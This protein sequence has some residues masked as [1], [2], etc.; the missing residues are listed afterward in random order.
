ME[1]DL[2]SQIKR[3][4]ELFCRLLDGFYV[5]EEPNELSLPFYLDSENPSKDLYFICIVL[6][7]FHDTLFDTLNNMNL[8][9]EAKYIDFHDNLILRKNRRIFERNTFSVWRELENFKKLIY[10]DTWSSYLTITNLDKNYDIL[11]QGS[12][13]TSILYKLNSNENEKLIKEL[14]SHLSATELILLLY[15]ENLTLDKE[16]WLLNFNYKFDKEKFEQRKNRL[17]EVLETT[18]NLTEEDI[19]YSIILEDIKDLLYSSK[20]KNKLEKLYLDSNYEELKR[21]ITKILKV[22]SPSRFQREPL[23]VK[24]KDMAIGLLHIGR[25]D[26]LPELI[27]E[28]ES[29]YD[30][31]SQKEKLQYQQFHKKL[32]NYFQDMF[33]KESEILEDYTSSIGFK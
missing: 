23:A 8:E 3:V 21:E 20:M 11:T 29:L 2:K 25:K 12:I 17:M 5:M 6:S 22:Y 13:I 9:K 31:I 19:E 26:D 18:K 32:D 24:T 30:L 27:K 33:E 16:A 4:D 10:G 14:R 28:Y 15:F 7:N 1:V